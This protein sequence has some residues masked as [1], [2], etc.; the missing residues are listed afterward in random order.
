MQ[1]SLLLAVL[2]LATGTAALPAQQT[3]N[4]AN[5]LYRPFSITM[6]TISVPPIAGVPFSA[7]AVIKNEQLMPD[8][9]VQTFNNINLIGRDSRGRTHGE[10]RARVPVDFKGDP[11]LVEVHIYDPQAHLKT[12]CYTATHIATRQPQPMPHFAVNPSRSSNPQVKI[13]DL[14]TEVLGN[15]DV[16]G[17][18]RT[19]TLPGQVTG[20]GA[21]IT[22]VD[23]YWYSEDLHLNVVFRHNDP[24]TGLQSIALTDIKRE[25]PNPAFFEIPAGY[26]VVDMTPP[27]DAPVNRVRTAPGSPAQ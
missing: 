21:P 17:T 2:L 11:P 10:M 23:E 16:R 14:G 12:V 5:P 26:K 15:I 1:R 24:R 18:R 20:T 19:L 25:E 8:G 7:T 3:S 4:D 22:V 9:T 13:E 27:P 6:H